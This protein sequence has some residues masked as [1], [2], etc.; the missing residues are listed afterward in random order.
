[1]PGVS[2]AANHSLL[3]LALAAGLGALDGDAGAAPVC[4]GVLAIG[5]TS[6]ITSGVLKRALPRHR[7]PLE[8]FP[9]VGLRVRPVSS[10]MPSG[11]AASAAAFATAAAIEAPILA[12]PLGAL[13]ATVA[14]SRVYNGVHYPG[15]VLLGGAIGVAVAAATVKVWPRA[16]YSPA[17][18]RAGSAA[19]RR[20]VG[21]P[22]ADGSGLTIVVN[23]AARSGRGDDPTDTLGAALPAA[24]II[25]LDDAGE[26]ED[27]LQSAASDTNTRAIGVM[28]GDG[29]INTAVG[30]ALEHDCPLV[31]VPGGTLNHFAR[32]IGLDSV[33]DA[34]RAVQSGQLVAIDVG[35][36]DEHVF[37]N[38]ASFGSYSKL[39]E[40][41]EKLEDRIGKWA[42]LAIALVRVLRHD[43]PSEITIDGRP[44]R[45]WMIFIGNGAYDPPG[46]APSTGARL[47]D[48]V[49]DVRIVD[50]SAPWARVRLVAALL[51]GN[52]A[53][54][55][56][57]S[58][59]LVPTVAVTTDRDETT[60]A[61]D[62]EIFDGDRAFSVGQEPEAAAR[63]RARV[64]L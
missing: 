20:V 62:G 41:R 39:V 32:D 25:V 9:F 30:V 27:A 63:V 1:M 13:A 12:V 57:Y 34:I 10:S 15:D 52:L 6:A 55:K 2:T 58:R 16:D 60:L 45:I 21:E 56:I 36:I 64:R 46:F 5:A 38:T 48:G 3:W 8:A 61:A 11:H 26:L 19:V 4:G 50:G 28:G 23:P 17:T 7:P 40:E 47:D 54:S 31:V 37:V 59:E 14:Y 22:S 35:L 33:D 43:E 29:S 24:K 53:R 18:A 49:F 42:A 44:R 51:T